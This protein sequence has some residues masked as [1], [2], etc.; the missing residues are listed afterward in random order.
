[1]ATI[2]F[3]AVN[4]S[5]TMGIYFVVVVCFALAIFNLLPLPVLDGGHI[6]FALIEAVIRRP[7][8]TVVIKVL[9]HAFIVLLI[10][11]MVYVTYFDILRLL[12]DSRK[13]EAAPAALA[14][15]SAAVQAAPA[16]AAPVPAAA[17]A[18]PV[19]AKK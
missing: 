7:L 1:M 17:P 10:A 14:P 18:T 2:L 16:A 15:A 13:K 12:P 6:A 8:P 9:S 3:G 11:L 5:F 4:H 19:E